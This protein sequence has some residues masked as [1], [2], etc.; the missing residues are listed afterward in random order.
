MLTSLQHAA[1]CAFMTARDTIVLRDRQAPATHATIRPAWHGCPI[2]TG[3]PLI[4]SPDLQVLFDRRAQ[5]LTNARWF[6]LANGSADL[7]QLWPEEV[8]FLTPQRAA[9]PRSAVPQT[10]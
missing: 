2:D 7:C 4:H 10:L 8:M 1:H 9:D 5:G 3:T 6:I